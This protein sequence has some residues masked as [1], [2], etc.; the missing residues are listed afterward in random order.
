MTGHFACFDPSAG[1]CAIA[2]TPD[3]IA[4]LQF[5]EADEAALRAFAAALTET[6]QAGRARAILDLL[7]EG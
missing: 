7:K 5:P 1:R 4:G 6:G 2:W 3:G